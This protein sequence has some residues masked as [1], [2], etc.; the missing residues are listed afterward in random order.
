MESIIP[1]VKRNAKLA[2]D[3]DNYRTRYSEY[4]LDIFGNKTLEVIFPAGEVYTLEKNF[5]TLLAKSKKVDF[6]TEWYQRP[7]YVSIEFYGTSIY[8]IIILFINCIDS[9][10]DFKDLSEI[11]IPNFNVILEI[12]KDKISTTD[13]R[14]IECISDSQVDLDKTTKYKIYPL[15]DKEIQ[16]IKAKEALEIIVEVEDEYE[17]FDYI[18]DGGIY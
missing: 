14:N 5:F 6:K 9:I 18:V 17:D 7:D 4:E 1:E 16:I 12:T 11:L 13:N 15:N 2:T 3:I 10:E 8:W